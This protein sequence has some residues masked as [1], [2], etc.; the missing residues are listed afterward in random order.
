M[1][2]L[3]AYIK[4]CSRIFDTLERWLDAWIERN[5]KAEGWKKQ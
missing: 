3:G 1:D 2:F 4:V 5:F